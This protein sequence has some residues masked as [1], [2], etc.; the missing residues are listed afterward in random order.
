MSRGFRTLTVTSIASLA[1]VTGCTSGSSQSSPEKGPSFSSSPETGPS[2]GDADPK[3]QELAA[4]VLKITQTFPGSTEGKPPRS[5]GVNL[6]LIGGELSVSVQT[7]SAGKPDPSRPEQIG[8]TQ[9]L[10]GNQT[11]S[12][13]YLVRGDGSVVMSCTDHTGRT[14]GVDEAT[15]AVQVGNEPAQYNPALAD[16]YLDN[17]L[18]TAT[19]IATKVAEQGP[20]QSVVPSGDI[21]ELVS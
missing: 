3:V 4:A 16:T 10:A 8:L 1:L 9:T 17:S 2:T 11:Y 21:C 12:L 6:P 19:N 15:K 7:A 13:N 18:Q 14:I 20:A 5:I